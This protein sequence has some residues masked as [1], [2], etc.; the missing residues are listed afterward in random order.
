MPASDSVTDRV[1]FNTALT[2][3][4]ASIAHQLKDRLGVSYKAL[5]VIALETLHEQTVQS[6]IRAA[7]AM[8]LRQQHLQRDDE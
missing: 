3:R 8:T 6:D 7:Q 5:L 2:G 4:T 1:R